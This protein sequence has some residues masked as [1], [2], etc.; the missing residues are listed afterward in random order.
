MHMLDVLKYGNRT[1]IASLERLPGHAWEIP[2]ACGH[3]SPK[4]ILAHLA[5]YELLLADV[6]QSLTDGSVGQTLTALRD[7]GDGFNDAQVSARSAHTVE[8]LQDEYNAAHRVSLARAA[9]ID[10]AILTRTGALEWYGSEYDLED[11]VVY[12]SYGHKREHAAQINAFVGLL[13]A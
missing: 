11:Y 13:R 6:F 8:Q 4:D 5:S 10:S 1:W 7:Q 3:W 12:S 2:G 9:V